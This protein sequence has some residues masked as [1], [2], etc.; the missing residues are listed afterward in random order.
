MWLES[1][2]TVDRDIQRRGPEVDG[3]Y[4]LSGIRGMGYEFWYKKRFE[5]V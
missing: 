5:P 4:A 1:K 2:L 3:R